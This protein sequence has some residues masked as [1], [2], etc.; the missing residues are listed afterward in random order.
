MFSAFAAA[1]W[2]I[3]ST[4]ADGTNRRGLGDLLKELYQVD[5]SKVISKWVGETEK[6]LARIFEAADAGHALLLFD[7]ADALFSRR[8]EV[9]SAIDRYAPLAAEPG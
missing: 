1:E 3:F 4:F 8:T 5:L 6:Q 9:K 7:E 2:T